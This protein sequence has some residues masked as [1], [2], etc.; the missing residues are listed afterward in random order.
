MDQKLTEKIKN[1]Y[2][3]V[4]GLYDSMD[5]MMKDSWRKELLEHVK[6][7]VLEVGIG[8]GA[9]L[10]FY[11]PDI[12]LTGIDFSPGM[13]KRAKKKVNTQAFPYPIDLIEVDAQQMSFPDNTFDY[14][15]ATCVYCS[16]PDPIKRLKEMGRVCKP[17]GKIL[18]LEHMR[19]DNEAAGKVMDLLNPIAVNMWGANINRKT[20]DN[21]NQAGLTIEQKEELFISVVRKLV[22]RPNK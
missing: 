21:I 8:T 13:L 19:S 5:G 17:D 20:L 16:V 4:S 12:H 18:L 14:V 9:N 15:V 2:N 3:R 1:R 10:S 22:V 6:G 7:E 11:P